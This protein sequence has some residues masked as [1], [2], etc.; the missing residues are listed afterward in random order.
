MGSQAALLPEVAAE[1]GLPA[2]VVAAILEQDEALG[3][4]DLQELDG[5]RQGM[6]PAHEPQAQLN[7]DVPPDVKQLVV[8]ARAEYGVPTKVFVAEAI[9]HYWSIVQAKG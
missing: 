7:I 1:A 5:R 4:D 8:R 9:R 2:S 6:P 3:G